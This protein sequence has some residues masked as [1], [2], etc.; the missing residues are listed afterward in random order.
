[1][2]KMPLPYAPASGLTIKVF[3]GQLLQYSKTLLKSAGIEKVS[4]KKSKSS[5]NFLN[6]FLR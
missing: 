5:G 2:R 4:G 1:M 3:L 6:I